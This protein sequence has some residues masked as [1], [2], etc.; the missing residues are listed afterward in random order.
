MPR[1]PSSYAQHTLVR[2]HVT[3]PGVLAEVVRLRWQEFRYPGFSPF[4]LEMICF[5]LRKRREHLIT[6]TFASDTAEVQDALDC[7]LAGTY[8]GGPDARGPLVQAV[9]CEQANAQREVPRGKFAKWREHVCYSKVLA[10]CIEE[11]WR[12]CGYDSFSAYVTG[13]IRYDLLLLGPHEHYTG[14]DMDPALLH[15]LDQMTRAEFYSRERPATLKIDH[16]LEKAAGRRLAPHERNTRMLAVVAILKDWAL[17]AA[18]RG[19]RANDTPE[20]LRAEAERLFK[21]L[22]V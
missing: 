16:L 22:G 20:Q 18:K 14:D 9:M 1:K 2:R 11:R 10:P 5:D 13:L 3:L 4:A 17:K 8:C 7:G 12:E 21:A 6:A 15:A 19:G